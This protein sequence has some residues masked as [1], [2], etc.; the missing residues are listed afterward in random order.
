M[1]RLFTLAS[2]LG[3]YAFPLAAAEF[4]HVP[5]GHVRYEE[6]FSIFVVVLILS[7]LFETALS[8]IYSWHLYL[9]YMEGRGF[10]TVINVGMAYLMLWAYDLDVVAD[11]LTALQDPGM[12]P[13]EQQTGGRW[14]TA[15]LIAGGSDGVFKVMTRLK[16]RDPQENRLRA[17]AA[18][19][20][21]VRRQEGL[22]QEAF[23]G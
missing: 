10:K 21:E 19:N 15:L 6:V 13:V 2:I 17:I 22:R 12:A 1:F 16:I 7:V 5:L 8:P 18:G 9:R 11:L 4:A 3:L 23:R 20:D 14:L